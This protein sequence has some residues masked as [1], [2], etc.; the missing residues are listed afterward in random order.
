MA[1]E[2]KYQIDK[3]KL[4]SLI[5]QELKPYIAVYSE[6]TTMPRK[7]W[8][9][10]TKREYKNAY[11]NCYNRLRDEY[12]HNRNKFWSQFSAGNMNVILEEY[13]LHMTNSGNVLVQNNGYNMIKKVLLDHVIPELEKTFGIHGIRI[14]ERYCS[15]MS[16]SGLLDFSQVEMIN[17]DK[18]E[19][20]NIDKKAEEIIT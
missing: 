17:N 12:R 7:E 18:K 4:K 10:N 9:D 19:E 20:D 13:G 2:S 11:S 16:Y 15:A 8:S 14:V 1:R 3:N 5:L 6:V